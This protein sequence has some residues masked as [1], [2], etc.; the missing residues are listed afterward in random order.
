MDTPIQSPQIAGSSPSVLDA[1]GLK[2]QSQYSKA[3]AD[4]AQPVA[5]FQVTV[6]DTLDA[7][8]DKEAMQSYDL[9]SQVYTMSTITPEQEKG[10]LDAI[11]G[12]VP[13]VTTSPA[14]PST[15]SRWASITSRASTAARTASWRS[16]TPPRATRCSK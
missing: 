5:G 14:S 15:G 2:L 12:G 16:R 4:R 3:K 13:V 9:I 1:L 7:Y 11:E 6:C 8:L 10:L